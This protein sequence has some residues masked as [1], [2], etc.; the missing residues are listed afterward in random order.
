MRE[1]TPVLKRVLNI[2]TRLFTSIPIIE[3]T[4]KYVG[5]YFY[6]IP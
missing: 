1:E 5:R 4:Y 2:Q 6:G 3:Q